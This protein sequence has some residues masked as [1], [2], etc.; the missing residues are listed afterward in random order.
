MAQ[1]QKYKDDFVLL[2]E[3]GFIAASQ[4]DEDAAMKLFRAAQISATRKRH[5]QS[6]L[7]IY[8]SPQT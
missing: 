1:L 3:S 5:A 8:P 2:L 6:R 7:W 4:T